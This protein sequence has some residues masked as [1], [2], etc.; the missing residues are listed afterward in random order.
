MPM[1][2]GCS[3][4]RPFFAAAVLYMLLSFSGTAHAWTYFI[5]DTN[6]STNVTSLRGAIIAANRFGFDTVIVL[7]G[8]ESYKRTYRQTRQWTYHL[9]IPGADETNSFTGDL[10]I[11]HGK[12]TIIGVG[13]NVT[14]DATGLGD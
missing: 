7:G 4:K 3:L 8:E 5:T 9:T 13:T 10:D 1:T 2:K 6:D 11:V 12:V 14:I